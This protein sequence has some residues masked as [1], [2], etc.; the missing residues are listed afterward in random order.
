MIKV[1]P[2]EHCLHQFTYLHFERTW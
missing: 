1:I 2:E